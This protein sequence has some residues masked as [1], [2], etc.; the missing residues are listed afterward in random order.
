MGP[1]IAPRPKLPVWMAETLD[2]S[3]SFSI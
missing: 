2:S 1:R 3:F